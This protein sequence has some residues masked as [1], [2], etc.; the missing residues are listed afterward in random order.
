M[1][2]NADTGGPLDETFTV[3]D[4]AEPAGPERVKLTAAAADDETAY[5]LIVTATDPSDS[6]A[7]IYVIVTVNDVDEAPKFDED[8]SAFDN[9]CGG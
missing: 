8:Q 7:S 2:L 1:K 5:I 6:S 3:P 9:S 4:E